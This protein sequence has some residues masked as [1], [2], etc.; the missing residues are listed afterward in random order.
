MGQTIERGVDCCNM[1]E[2]SRAGEDASGVVGQVLVLATRR[3][4]EPVNIHAPPLFSS[5]FQAFDS[6]HFM[7]LCACA[8]W[9]VR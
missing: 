5:P 8:P 9:R 1:N 7:R 3:A 4:G 2:E 6:K